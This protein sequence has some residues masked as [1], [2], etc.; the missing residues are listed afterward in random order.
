MQHTQLRFQRWYHII[1]TGED[2]A[3]HPVHHPANPMP[4]LIICPI[5]KPGV[6]KIEPKN[7]QVFVTQEK[8][9]GQ[10]PTNQ[11][12]TPWR[13]MKLLSQPTVKPSRLYQ[14]LFWVKFF[15]VSTGH[16]EI[17]PL[18][19]PMPCVLACWLHSCHC[20][21]PPH[22]RLWWRREEQFPSTSI[23]HGKCVRVSVIRS[24]RRYIITLLSYFC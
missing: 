15:T 11:E 4:W 21:V 12:S 19:I 9:T 22:T 8:K 24:I 17:L 23:Y 3:E 18:F 10:Q 7:E 13:E 16:R 20:H 14:L 1:H 5:T 6:R 2:K